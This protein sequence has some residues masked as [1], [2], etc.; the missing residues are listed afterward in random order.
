MTDEEKRVVK[1][2]YEK[3]WVNHP[4]SDEFI[5]AV[6]AR[7]SPKHPPK[8]AI[9]EV[10]TGNSPHQIRIATGTGRWVTEM[11]GDGI[12]GERDHYRVIHTAQDAQEVLENAG[13]RNAAA[14]V[15]HLIDN[16]ET[17]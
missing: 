17:G 16:A 13:F 6:E 2:E 14:H 15:K 9:C 3:R 1:N 8:E 10:W 4:N 11:C 12:S 5:A 7:L